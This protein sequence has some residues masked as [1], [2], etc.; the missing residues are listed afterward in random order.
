MNASHKCT[1][2]SSTSTK[3]AAVSIISIIT[4]TIITITIIT[5]VEKTTTTIR[6]Q[7]QHLTSISMAKMKT[8][9]SRGLAVRMIVS[10]VTSIIARSWRK[11]LTVRH[12][13][14]RTAQWVHISPT[15]D[16]WES[17]TTRTN[18]WSKCLAFIDS[19]LE[20]NRSKICKLLS[21][22]SIT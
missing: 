15:T 18:S 11:N 8:V 16:A 12:M 13:I 6:L 1:T 19:L 4:S 2:R 20:P 10:G 5:Q 3:S 9:R 7:P 14:L 17:M 22:T 21:T